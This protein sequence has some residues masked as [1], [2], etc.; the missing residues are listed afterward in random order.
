VSGG[1]DSVVLLHAL[2]QVQRLLSLAIEV[3]HVN[4]G[5]R[6]DS[7][8]DEAFVVQLCAE[9]GLVC[10]VERLP[11]R[12]RGE[13]IEAWARARRYEAFNRIMAER[14]LDLVL[15]AHNA[16]DVAETLLMRLIAN[17]ELNSIEEFDPRRRV[18]RPLIEVSREQINEYISENGLSFVE[19]PSNDDPTFVRNRLR[20]EVLPILAER[21]DPS[22]V[23]ILSERAQSLA[24]D[25][26]ALH[27]RAS[28]VAAG[29]GEF[30]QGSGAWLERCRAE[31]GRVPP[32]VRWR[33][34]QIV[35][36]PLLGFTVGE[37]RARAI[38]GVLEGLQPSLQ[39]GPGVTLQVGKDGA[40]ITGFAE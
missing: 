39:I 31:L 19:D 36:T 1:R 24:A 26:D 11:T 29:V 10:H 9:L 23:W 30:E 2:V 22:I 3:C 4:H 15:T 8:E 33:V 6:P 17:K 25:S 37:S 18:V 40:K 32:A 20:H 12:P 7:H 13:N 16:N 27:E 5:L 35:F 28:E 14:S 38:A 21:F 34:V